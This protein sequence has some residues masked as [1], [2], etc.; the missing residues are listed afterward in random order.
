VTALLH[1]STN[2]NYM[3]GQKSPPFIV[4]TLVTLNMLENSNI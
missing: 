1:S 4:L 2:I 3:V